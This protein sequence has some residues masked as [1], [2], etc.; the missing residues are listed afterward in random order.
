M[1]PP[2]YATGQAA[3][4]AASLSLKQSVSPREVDIEHLRKTLQEQGAVV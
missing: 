2:C 3:G 1:I 4:T